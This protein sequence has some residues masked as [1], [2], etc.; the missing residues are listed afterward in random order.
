MESVENVVQPEP[1]ENNVGQMYIPKGIPTKITVASRCSKKI[2]DDYY[3]L[4]Y[5][6]ERSIP[7][8][9]NI[10]LEREALWDTCNNE[11]DRAI[12][13]TWQAVTN[14]NNN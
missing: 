4:E 8:G 2:G 10:E 11:V 7:E 9:A 13:D 5:I 1:V 6:E 12:Y 3:T 14:P